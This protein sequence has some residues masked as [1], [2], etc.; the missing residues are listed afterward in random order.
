MELRMNLGLCYRIVFADDT[1]M[2]FRYLGRDASG[3]PLIQVPPSGGER[4]VLTR[5]DIKDFYQIDVP[6]EE[7]ETV[8]L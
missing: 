4:Q 1:S 3:R 8:N 2:Q 5:K 7:M 6:S